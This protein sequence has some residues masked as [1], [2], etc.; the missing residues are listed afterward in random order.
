MTSVRVVAFAGSLRRGSYNRSLL[1]ACRELA[2][3]SLTDEKT[4]AHLG[5]FL[6][7]FER[8][9]RRFPREG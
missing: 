8:W 9:I 6:A 1:A 4:R 3:E 5:R 2:P 7:A